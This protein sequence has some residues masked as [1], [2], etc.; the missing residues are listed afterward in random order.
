MG[1]HF[2]FRGDVHSARWIVDSIKEGKLLDKEDYF[3][4]ECAG[5]GIKRIEFGKGKVPY[6]MTEA[7]KIFE[8]GLANASRSRGATFWQE[9]ERSSIIPK[10]TSDSMR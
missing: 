10:R 4:Y 8:I 5:E 6:T 3:R 1:K 2:F 9:V 7:I